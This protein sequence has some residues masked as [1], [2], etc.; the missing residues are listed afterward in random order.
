MKQINELNAVSQNYR[1][2]CEDYLLEPFLLRG[3]EIMISPFD[4]IKS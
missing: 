2:T 1:L 4:F 3:Q